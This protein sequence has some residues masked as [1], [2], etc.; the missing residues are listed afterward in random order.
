MNLTRRAL[1]AGAGSLALV[2][3]VAAASSSVAVVE[4]PAFGATWRAVIEAGSDLQAL[5][6]ALQGVVASVNAAMSPFRPGSE[7]GRFN[8][9]NDTDWFALSQQTC[10][11][12]TEALRVAG[13]TGGAF[14]PTM[15][16]VVGQFGFG[17]ISR[18][19][20][21][22][23]ADI[24]VRAGAVRKALPDLTLDLCGIAKGYALDRMADGIERAGVENY[25]LE[26]GGEVA[27]RGRHPAG[28]AWQVGV[29]RP[30]TVEPALQRIVAMAG[31]AMA[32]S[33][34]R[35]NSYVTGGRRYSHIIDPHERWPA[36][37]GLASVS[38]LAPTGMQA[39][40]MA[41]ALFAMGS[42]AGPDFAQRSGL[43]ALF[44]VR[45]NAGVREIMT[46]G[47]ADRILT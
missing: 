10:D 47:F 27:A 8:A 15:G 38:V 21:G 7:I 22:G 9:S 33:G 17:P 31:D 16:G 20:N 19:S 43:P 25:L 28:R 2:R 29:E 4:G 26:V 6:T 14:D 37:A 32:T 42:R 41:T 23:H 24:S 3:P 45:E 39:D 44:L 40:A 46:G 5:A 30:E 12:V 35:V 13:V 36:D 11:V 18:R 34:D 1:L